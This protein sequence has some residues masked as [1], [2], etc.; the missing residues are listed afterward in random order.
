MIPEDPLG[1]A[2]FPVPLTFHVE[3]LVRRHACSKVGV[4]LRWEAVEVGGRYVI[5]YRHRMWGQQ[6]G[7]DCMQKPDDHV[8]LR[9]CQ[10]AEGSIRCRHDDGTMHG[11]E[12]ARQSNHRGG[13]TAG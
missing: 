11:L 8:R 1:E 6:V 12:T 9:P 4:D 2:A 10:G 5:W 13:A 7:R 3:E